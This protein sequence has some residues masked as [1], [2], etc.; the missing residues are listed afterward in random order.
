MWENAKMKLL[1]C[2]DK[3]SIDFPYFV[4]NIVPHNLM[5][6]S[7]MHECKNIANG[8]VVTWHTGSFVTC[9]LGI[10]S[11]ALT[12]QKK[13]CKEHYSGNKKFFHQNVKTKFNFIFFN[14]CTSLL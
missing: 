2:G 14:S 12:K 7:S 8:L 4:V 1:H 5:I 3:T 13:N 9:Y 6:S 10:L 11:P